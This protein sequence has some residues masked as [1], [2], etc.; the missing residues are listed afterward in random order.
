MG[1]II[2]LINGKDR[3]AL[4]EGPI[5]FLLCGPDFSSERL[6]EKCVHQMGPTHHVPTALIFMEITFRVLHNWHFF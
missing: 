1:R 2:S 3:V 5:I 4:A 6:C